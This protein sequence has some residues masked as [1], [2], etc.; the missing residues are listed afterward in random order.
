[1]ARVS[2]GVRLPN[3]GPFASPEAIREVAVFS[4]TRGLGAVW[5]HD[6]IAWPAERRMHFAAGSVEGV[7]N[8]PPD[9]YESLST[10]AYVAGITRRINVGVAG[11]VLPF[12]D[13]RVLGK[14]LVTIDALASGR[15]I[16]ALAIG[17]YSDEFAAQ[18]VPYGQR[19]RITDEHLACLAA[20]FSPQPVTTFHGRRIH[21]EAAEYF[22][23]A[24]GLQLWICGL[25]PQAMRRVAQFG[26]GWLP[27]SLSSGDYAAGL[28]SL[29]EAMTVLGRSIEEITPA[30]EIYTCIAETDAEARLIAEQ[31][32]DYLFR[33]RDQGTARML[34]GSPATVRVRIAEYIAVGVTHF[35]LKFICHSLAQMQEMIARCA[36][37]VVREFR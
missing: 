26:R 14:Q 1:M 30:L 17:R 28:V 15:L 34:V 10:I 33:E 4:E 13:P 22:P 7:T 19:G 6:H 18:E 23:K 8:Q 2:F 37:D 25:S 31:S 27:G 29:R 24:I 36:D 16:A 21:I 32:L 11:L 20:I 35:E 5:V 3:S 9:F 12:R